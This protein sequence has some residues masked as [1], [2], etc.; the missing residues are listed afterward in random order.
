MAIKHQS[1]SSSL[2]VLSSV[3]LSLDHGSFFEHNKSH[4]HLSL[5]ETKRDTNS[6]KH[7]IWHIIYWRLSR[8]RSAIPRLRLPSSYNRQSIL[9][10]KAVIVAISKEANVP[11]T[12]LRHR[13][14][15]SSL[16]QVC[17][18]NNRQD[19]EIC[20]YVPVD[21]VTKAKKEITKKQK[22]IEHL[23]N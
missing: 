9:Y 23:L 16:R 4:R 22:H 19:D 3:F 2:C 11:E 12:F 17:T 10:I 18:S 21:C 8:E 6:F 13:P 5:S 1:S 14:L 20:H 15:F 7:K